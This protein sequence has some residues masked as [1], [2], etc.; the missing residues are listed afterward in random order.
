LKLAARADGGARAAYLDDARGSLAKA[1]ERAPGSGALALAELHFSLLADG[2]PSRAALDGVIAAARTTRDSGPLARAAV[3]AWCY[4]VDAPK[5]E[6]V[7]R[8]LENDVRDPD[9]TAW[10]VQFHRRLDAGLT[11]ADIIGEM[12]K[13]LDGAAPAGGGNEW[14]LDLVSLMKDVEVEAGLEYARQALQ[15]QSQ[16]DMQKQM[17]APS[18]SA[19]PAGR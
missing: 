4:L 10:A 8:M 17:S 7:L 3:L 13:D 15:G 6:H 5:A 14:T 16:M 1:R 11:L 9:L 18:N 12:R 19:P 2:R